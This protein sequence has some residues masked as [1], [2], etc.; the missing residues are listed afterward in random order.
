METDRV[1]SGNQVETTVDEN[2]S[3]SAATLKE[4]RW[5]QSSRYFAPRQSRDPIVLSKLQST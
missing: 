2:H 4:I 5:F 3:T 1:L